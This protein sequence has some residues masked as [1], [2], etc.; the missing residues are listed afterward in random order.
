MMTVMVVVGMVRDMRI[1]IILLIEMIDMDEDHGAAVLVV[2]GVVAGA[3][4][5]G[6]IEVQFEKEVKR[7]EQ[8]LNSGTGKENKQLYLPMLMSQCRMEG[9]THI[10]TVMAISY[11]Y[12]FLV[13]SFLSPG[14]LHCALSGATVAFLLGHQV[15]LAYKAFYIVQVVC[16]F[17]VMFSGM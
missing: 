12:L 16:R 17:A 13:C 10:S 3:T 6:G 9:H 4:V 14:I 2:G 7:G 11:G 5:L 8:K 1:E 15:K